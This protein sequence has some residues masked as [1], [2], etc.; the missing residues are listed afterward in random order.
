MDRK[1]KGVV[2]IR[3]AFAC[4]LAVLTVG[5]APAA[6]G[7]APVR[8]GEVLRGNFVQLRQMKG[9]DKPLKAEGRFTIAPGYGLIW[10]VEKPFASVTVITKTGL[11]QETAGTRTTALSV[12]KM[13]FVAQ[14]YDLIGGMLTGDMEALQKPFVVERLPAG[15]GWRIRLTPKKRG[16][17]MMPFVEIRAHGGRA[18]ED[19]VM[20][21]TGGD[22]DTLTFSNVAVVK[23][24]PSDEEKADFG[25]SAL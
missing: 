10:R 6:E 21:K 1:G 17:A 23:A 2:M 7:P 22:T 12:K 8:P 25:R 4:L 14:L 11:L 24:A 18:V 5:I 15:E 9:F 16:D 20:V 3:L 13:P 19:V